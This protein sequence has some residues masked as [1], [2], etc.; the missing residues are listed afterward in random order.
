MSIPTTPRRY[1]RVAS[2]ALAILFTGIA[3][4]ISVD[5]WRVGESVAPACQACGAGGDGG[6][7]RR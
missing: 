3:L 4:R 2:V 5:F 1:T 6:G 7:V